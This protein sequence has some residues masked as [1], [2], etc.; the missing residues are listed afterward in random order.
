MSNYFVGDSANQVFDSY[1][2]YL[3]AT[4]DAR[5]YRQF[6]SQW[7]Q[8]PEPKQAEAIVFAW[9]CSAGLNPVINESLTHGG[10]DF[11]CSPDIGSPFL[12]EVTVIK[13]E[14][15]ERQS[16]LSNDID[17]PGGAFRFITIT[18]NMQVRSKWDQFVN[19]EPIPRVMAIASLHTRADLLLGRDAAESLLTSDPFIR[20]AVNAKGLEQ[21]R[22]STDLRNSAFFKLDDADPPN[23]LLKNHVVSAIL[24][25]PIL[26][27]RVQPVG[28]LHPDPHYQFD[29]KSLHLV[30]LGGIRDWPLRNNQ[31]STRW[32]Y[33]TDPVTYY[34]R[35]IRLTDSERRNNQ[36]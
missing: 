25:F 8:D 2:E 24:L 33:D 32:T 12:L 10:L 34:H 28:I 4:Q 22:S 18:L 13:I 30:P 17:H 26:E 23:V 1:C 9:A 35:R 16:K 14:T 5:F 36:T 20:Y 31:I 27:D 29:I 6:I 19:S 7:E 11:R 21:G 15:V 3:A